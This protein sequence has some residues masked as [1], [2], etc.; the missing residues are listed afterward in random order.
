MNLNKLKSKRIKVMEYSALS[1]LLRV[2]AKPEIISMA[3]GLPAPEAFPF[4]IISALNNLVLKK[5]RSVSLQYG[6]TNGVL[7][8]RGEI[9]KWLEERKMKVTS[10]NIGIT[11]GSQGGLDT[12]GKIFINEGDKIAVESPTYIGAID[13]FTSYGPIYEEIKTDYDQEDQRKNG[14]YTIG[15]F[16]RER[17]GCGVSIYI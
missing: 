2:T 11:S 4:K 3:G 7:V 16:G 15:R 13:A 12:L 9:A 17:G 8:L 5:H 10:E 14:H 1:E 6:P